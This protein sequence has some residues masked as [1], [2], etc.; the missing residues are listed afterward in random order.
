MHWRTLKCILAICIKALLLLIIFIALSEISARAERVSYCWCWPV[1]L[2]WSWDCVLGSRWSFWVGFCVWPQYRHCPC[3]IHWSPRYPS[4]AGHEGR[5]HANAGAYWYTLPSMLSQ[6]TGEVKWACAYSFFYCRGQGRDEK[7]Q[8]RDNSL[9]LCFLLECDPE[10][11][12][13]TG[14][15]H[16][17]SYLLLAYLYAY[18]K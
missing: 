13:L 2:Q 9:T 8:L 4:G 10:Q 6:N 11:L 18:S 14:F 1:S 16:Q 7:R 5:L 15:E 17:S 12:M 3:Q